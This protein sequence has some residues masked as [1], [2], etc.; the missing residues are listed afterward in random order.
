MIQAGNG[1]GSI[2]WIAVESPGD[3]WPK[4][5]GKDASAGPF[6]L[7]WQYPERSRVANEQWPY[8]LEKLTAVQSPA[9]RW[10]QLRVDAAPPADAPARLGEDVFAAQCLLC[11]RLDGGEASEIG[12]D[13]GQPMAATDYMTDPGCAHWCA[14]RNR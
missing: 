8:M 7:I 4:L 10:P 11:H 2:A 14:I 3:P 9:L 1:G 6:Y 13:L 12:P 5:P